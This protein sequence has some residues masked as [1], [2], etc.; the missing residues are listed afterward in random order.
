MRVLREEHAEVA[1]QVTHHA[2][3]V[4][5]GGRVAVIADC[6]DIHRRVLVNTVTGRTIRRA[7]SPAM[8]L[9]Y[10]TLMLTSHGWRLAALAYAG[11]SCRQ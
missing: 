3:L 7:R 4:S 6:Q 9:L 2:R 11:H 1:A 8:A 5:A 10:A